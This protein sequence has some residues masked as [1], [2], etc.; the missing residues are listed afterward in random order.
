[1]KKNILTLIFLTLL[2]I[3]SKAQTQNELIGK[4]VCIDVLNKESIDKLGLEYLESHILNKWIFLFK[5]NGF[6]E[7]EIIDMDYV[8][9]IW[10]YDMLS[11]KITVTGFGE[12]PTTFEILKFEKNSMELKFEHGEYILEKKTN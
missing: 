11:K 7:S 4:W 3:Q 10:E 12:S 8:K 2:S 1:M 6:Y 5:E 9:G